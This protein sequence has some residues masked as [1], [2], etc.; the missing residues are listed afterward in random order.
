LK[1]SSEEALQ[2]IEEKLSCFTEIRKNLSQKKMEKYSLCLKS[3]QKGLKR[4]G[5]ICYLN[6]IL[7]LLNENQE[8][9]NSLFSKYDPTKRNID[10]LLYIF[11]KLRFSY[12]SPVNGEKILKKNAELYFDEF[13]Q[14]DAS[15][16]FNDLL[17][18]LSLEGGEDLKKTLEIEF[19]SNLLCDVCK[20]PNFKVNKEVSF[21]IDCNENQSISSKIGKF[22]ENFRLEGENR[23][24]CVICA[25]KQNASQITT[26]KYL[27]ETFIITIKRFTYSVLEGRTIKL[28]TKIGIEK[29]ID[30]QTEDQELSRYYLKG[31]IVHIGDADS[32]HYYYIKKES[33]RWL[34]I[35]DEEIS[36]KPASSLDTEY[37][38]P[39]CDGSDTSTPYI[40]IYSKRLEETE[41][42][43]PDN[44]NIRLLNKNLKYYKLSQ[45]VREDFY[46]VVIQLVKQGKDYRKIT[47][48]LFLLSDVHQ[49]DE[50][51][52]INSKRLL[53]AFQ[54]IQDADSYIEPMISS[55]KS[56]LQ[57]D[58]NQDH[59]SYIILEV[60]KTILAK[61]N[62]E[63]HLKIYE[64][65][66][67]LITSE[68][69]T[70]ATFLFNLL[71][72]LN[73]DL[74]TSSELP[75]PISPLD[76]FIENFSS[77]SLTLSSIF[78]TAA[79]SEVLLKDFYQKILENMDFF[80][81]NLPKSSLEPFA[82]LLSKYSEDETNKIIKTISSS[83]NPQKYPLLIHLLG[84]IFTATNECPFNYFNWI[85]EGLEI[86]YYPM[87]LKLAYKS[88]IP[89][90]FK[91]LA[92][93]VKS[94]IAQ[95]ENVEQKIIQ[96]IMKI[97][98]DINEG[99]EIFI[100]F[101]G[102]SVGESFRD[103]ESGKVLEIVDSFQWV[104][105]VQDLE[106]RGLKI[107]LL[108]HD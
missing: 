84:N 101:Q 15:D 41:L 104:V 12:I 80:L 63:N 75:L 77:T 90:L 82:F 47:D 67:F 51:F 28:N 19:S 39:F 105:L 25:Q 35:N 58:Y 94:I 100:E 11:G 78:L 40:I 1:W 62:P 76:Y 61:V 30:V 18:S 8:F 98:K 38:I 32:G 57:F 54:S 17:E 45:F 92:E 44:I 97:F 83:Y 99:Q 55:L 24:E 5:M 10:S 6:T 27:P 59:R 37:T 36:I 70:D 29:E 60:L 65:I 72:H 85:L 3:T 16:F 68:S 69:L 87:F 71:L 74:L 64:N 79:S 89:P 56:S 52:I 9:L 46:E 106:T 107:K 2:M 21:M 95:S 108:Y 22:Y 66:S 13:E 26:L 93:S 31:I 4:E 73:F 7:L 42:Q 23:Y 86:N 53:A 102:R 81:S 43:L 91:N 49:P 103:W 50:H 14:R 34:L 20:T 96:E 88:L 48:Y 33:A